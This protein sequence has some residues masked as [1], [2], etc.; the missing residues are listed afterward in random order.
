MQIPSKLNITNL[1][2]KTFVKLRKYTCKRF[3]KLYD[4]K[5]ISCVGCLNLHCLSDLIT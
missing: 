1:A 4:K 5:K 2:P 3:W